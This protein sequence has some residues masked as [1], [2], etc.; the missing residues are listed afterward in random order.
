MIRRHPGDLENLVEHPAMLSRHANAAL[1]AFVGLKR[2]YQREQLD[3]FGASAEDAENLA[4]G[5]HAPSG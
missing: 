2:A 3:G 1:E 4:R 5:R